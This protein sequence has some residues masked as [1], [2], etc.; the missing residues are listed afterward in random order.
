M[1]QTKSSGSQRPPDPLLDDE[2]DDLPMPP[3]RGRS[4]RTSA[5]DDGGDP[6]SMPEQESIPFTNDKVRQVEIHMAARAKGTPVF[7]YPAELNQEHK[8]YW[9]ELVNSFP[10]GYFTAADIPTLKIYCRAAH[11]VDRCN[12]LIEEEGDVIMG[13]KGP[14]INP[15]VRV[16]KVSEDL[17]MTIATKFRA[18]PASRENT[19]NNKRN[20]AKHATAQ[21]AAQTVDNDEDGLLAGRRNLQ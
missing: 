8:A 18:Q 15:R 9:L 20:Q 13:G 14:T 12:K 7:P 10:K 11:D 6:L 2:E 5:D 17:I 3:P 4:R 21:N 19:T 16:R 1:A